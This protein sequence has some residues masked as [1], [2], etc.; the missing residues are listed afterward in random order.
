M[1]FRPR[2]GGEKAFSYAHCH[3]VAFIQQQ[4]GLC[5][6]AKFV[7][8][9]QH[10]KC[11]SRAFRCV[12]RVERDQMVVPGAVQCTQLK[13]L[14]LGVCAG[15]IACN[16]LLRVVGKIKLC[17]IFN[18]CCV[19]H[20]VTPAIRVG[21]CATSRH[22]RAKTFECIDVKYQDVSRVRASL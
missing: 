22:L 20:K 8:P 19:I 2:G 3:H 10:L 1:S 9:L 14:A 6:R 18:C 4:H 7:W 16:A 15:P 5:R 11:T 21:S 13:P 12:T 17:D